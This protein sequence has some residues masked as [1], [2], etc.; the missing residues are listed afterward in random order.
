MGK[1]TAHRNRMGIKDTTCFGA[2]TWKGLQRD[3][4]WDTARYGTDRATVCSAGIHNH[5]WDGASSYA[6]KKSERK[7]KVALDFG[8]LFIVW[9][10]EAPGYQPKDH[11]A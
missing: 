11:L 6:W 5:C 1:D 7:E 2:G 4:H 10:S 3:G 9:L 8:L